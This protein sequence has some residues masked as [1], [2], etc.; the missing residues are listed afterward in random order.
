MD[1]RKF[2]VGIALGFMLA[3]CE[4]PPSNNADMNVSPPKTPEEACPELMKAYCKKYAECFPFAASIGYPDVATCETRVLPICLK[5]ASATGSKVTGNALAACATTFN[6]A[7]CMDFVGSKDPSQLCNFPAGTVAA[8]GACGYD[9]QCQGLYCNKDNGDCGKCGTRGQIGAECVDQADCDKGLACVGAAG[10]SKCA[11]YL[12][13]DAV[14]S[15]ASGSVPCHPTLACRGGK[16]S[17]PAQENE[18]CSMGSKECNSLQGLIC[19]TSGKC[20]A[21]ATATL[22]QPCGLQGITYVSCKG[23]TWCDSSQ[24]KCMAAAIDGAACSSSGAKCL[25]PSSC[26][27]NTCGLFDPD[28]CK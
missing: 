28:T 12:A 26:L 27:N 17:Q 16:C 3:G 10:A 25:A 21:S 4:S 20:T 11:A 14:C 5:L 6:N 8:G 22:G 2:L 19:P 15:T 1:K 7:S 23:G 24:K 13:L 18:T 9:V